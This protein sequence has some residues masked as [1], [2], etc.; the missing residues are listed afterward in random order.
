MRFPRDPKKARKE[1]LERLK[2]TVKYAYNNSRYFR[3]KMDRAKFKPDKMKSFSDLKY[4]P[5]TTKNDL[6][7]NNW[8]IVA[9]PRKKWVDLLSTSGTTGQSVYIPMTKKDLRR[10]ARWGGQTLSLMGLKK[11]DI[12]Q[13]TLPMGSWLWMAGYGFYLCYVDFGCCVL[14]FGPGFTDKQIE[15]MEKLGTTVIHGVPSFMI[16]L[17]SA[18]RASGIRHHV[19]KVATI[20]ENVLTMDLKKNSAGKMIEENWGAELFSTYGSTEGPIVCCECTE[21]QGM[22]VHPFEVIIEI[23]DPDTYEPVPEGERGVITITPLG[24]EGFPLLRYAIGDLSFLVPGDCPCG[25][26]G[27]RIG[28]IYARTDHMMKIKGVIVYP[29]VLKEIISREPLV[30]QFQIEAYTENF[31]DHIR[32]WCAGNGEAGYI[33]NLLRKKIKE[34]LGISV[35]VNV[36]SSTDVAARILPPGKNKPVVFLDLREKK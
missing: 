26:Y 2:A 11:T 23:L 28:P 8:D 34:S 22:H 30:G 17:G 13:L 24:V 31:M 29:E 10:V 7:E 20:A 12:V 9:V 19:E 1:Q 25:A 4:L 3:E 32:I 5:V 6:R 16:R 18:V 35:E 33:S 15:I 21:H 27:Q 14:R 36:V